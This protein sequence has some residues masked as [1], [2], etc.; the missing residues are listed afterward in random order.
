MARACVFIPSFSAAHESVI[1]WF[2]FCPDQLLQSI[3]FMCWPFLYLDRSEKVIRWFSTLQRGNYRDVKSNLVR[4]L[5]WLCWRPVGYEGEFCLSQLP[6]TGP[7][8]VAMHLIYSFK[9]ISNHLP[10]FT[11][12]LPWGRWS[13]LFS[14]QY[15]TRLGYLI[16]IL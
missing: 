3:F 5:F 11:M 2:Q 6:V 9:T 10:K 7:A 14:E 4:F 12:F 13:C 16:A 8:T 15:Q 1:Y